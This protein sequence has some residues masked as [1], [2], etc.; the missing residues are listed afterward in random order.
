[1]S[2]WLMSMQRGNDALKTSEEVIP[3]EEVTAR[4]CLSI[5]I[6]SQHSFSSWYYKGQGST[7]YNIKGRGQEFLKLFCFQKQ[8]KI[9]AIIRFSDPE[10]RRK[11]IF[12]YLKKLFF[13]KSG[14]HLG[15]FGAKRGNFFPR[16]STPTVLHLKSSFFFYRLLVNIRKS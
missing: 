9:D 8:T 13:C 7:R 12:K 4:R 2:L 5:H 16:A 1:M 3:L 14:G 10:N 15:F 6:K 11:D